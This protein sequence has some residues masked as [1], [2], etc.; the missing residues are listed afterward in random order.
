V[1]ITNLFTPVDRA[2]WRAWLE[3]NHDCEK[4]VWLVYFKPASGR[5]NIDYETSVEEALCFGWIDSI[6]QKIDDEKYARKFNPRR[7]ESKWSETN[8]RRVIK[9]IREARMTE[10]GM[11]KVTFDVKKMDV[12][13]PKGKR[14]KAHMEMPEKIEK[15]IKSQPKV[16]DAFQKISPSHKRNYILWLSDAKKP[17]TFERRLKLLIEEVMAGKPTSMH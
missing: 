10:A 12:N 9:V 13:K 2:D 6:I 11:A 15:A 7:L 16:W 1:K 17:E 4:E 3:K 14:P 5:V 8:K